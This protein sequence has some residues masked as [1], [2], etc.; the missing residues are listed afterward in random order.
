MA[1]Y[2]DDMRASLKVAGRNYVMCHMLADSDEELH[3]M[4]DQI[5]VSRQYWQQP[6]KVS[7]SHYDITQSK[8]ALAVKAGAIEVTMQEMA[9]MAASR[10]L[11]GFMGHPA[12]AIGWYMAYRAEQR[13][14]QA[15]LEEAS[16]S[17]SKAS[18]KAAD[19]EQL[20]LT[21]SD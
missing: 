12:Q 18:S 10:R 21:F 8:R 2:V 3:E 5:G 9:A 17:A 1:V 14:T 13:P 4:A 19:S 15:L 20:M 6:P 11:R 7:T 16:R